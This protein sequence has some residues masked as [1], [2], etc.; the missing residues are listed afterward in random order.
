MPRGLAEAGVA[1][2]ALTPGFPAKDANVVR[3]L[4]GDAQSEVALGIRSSVSR[5]WL[6]S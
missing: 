6:T 5:K 2:G 4:A 1:E 3:G